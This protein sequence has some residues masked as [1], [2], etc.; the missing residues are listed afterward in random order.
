VRL[1]H[2]LSKE[3]LQDAFGCVARATS[4]ASVPGWQL[5]GGTLM[6][7]LR[8]TGGDASTAS[9]GG[10]GTGRCWWVGGR[11]RCWVL[12]DRP[13]VRRKTWSGRFL[14]L[15]AEPVVAGDGG[16]PTVC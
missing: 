6:V 11:A 9:F 14:G 16:V 10:L 13:R 1:D 5:T 7:G 8:M 15:L 2:L 12:R 4:R 3:L